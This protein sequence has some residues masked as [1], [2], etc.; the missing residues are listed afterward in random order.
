MNLKCIDGK[1]NQL[2][3]EKAEKLNKIYEELNK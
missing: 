1:S 3:K 2:D